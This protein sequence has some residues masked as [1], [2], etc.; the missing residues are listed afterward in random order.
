MAPDPDNLFH[1][2]RH[3]SGEEMLDAVEKL[4]IIVDDSQSLKPKDR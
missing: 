3:V 4:G 1:G 2:S